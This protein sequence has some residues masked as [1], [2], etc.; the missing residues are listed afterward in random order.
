MRDGAFDYLTKPFDLPA[1]LATVARALEQRRMAERIAPLP[2]AESG[3]LVGSSA[4]MLA[5]WKLIG[6]AAASTAP[7]L[8]TGETGVGKELVARAIHDYSTRSGEPFVA[9]NLAALPPSLL[10]SELFGHEKGAFTGASARR[11]GRFEAAGVGTLFLDEIGD[12]DGSLQTKL[13]RVL[14]DGTFERV[15]GQERLESHARIVAAT[16]K[17][18][19][20]SEPGCVLREDLYYRLAVVEIYLPPLR[21]RADDIQL[22]AKE[23]LSRYAS[24]NLK[25]NITSFTDEAWS[26]IL[27]FQW[28]GNVRELKNAVQRGVI[29]ARS[30][31]IGLS[32]MLQR[33]L[34]SAPEPTAITMPVGETTVADARRQLILKTFA[35]AGGDLARTA[36]MVSVS[37]DEVRGEL[38]A[39]L[40]GSVSSNGSL[41]ME[42]EA[43][44]AR[45]PD[46]IAA[47]RGASKGK[48]TKKK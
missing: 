18:V 39:L 23:F 15:G 41:S 9:V 21:E 47:A 13:L 24:E 33:H 48:P 8:I 38:M 29:M 43:R 35:A 37:V 10:E 31:K 3:S 42:A 19:A 6:R 4:A 45:K 32:D 36:K 22:L 2:R 1:L 17:P 5:T 44:I 28:P 11:A 14:H 34:R 7:V 20:P 30:D 46:N 26:W 25:A 40:E 27:S 12:L 16:N